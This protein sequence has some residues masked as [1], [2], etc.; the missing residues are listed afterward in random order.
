MAKIVLGE[1]SAV[2]L[3]TA[4]RETPS[5]FHHADRYSKQ[6]YRRRRE[7]VMATAY[8]AP[9]EEHR[10]FKAKPRPDLDR[11]AL[12]ADINERYK[13]SLAYLGR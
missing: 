8:R 13:N 10:K 12:R 11:E 3:L 1:R 7:I 2:R 9:V 4:D 5:T 6:G